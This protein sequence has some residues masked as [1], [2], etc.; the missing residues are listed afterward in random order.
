[1][2]PDFPWGEQRDTYL[3]EGLEWAR[4][5]GTIDVA[6]QALRA[7]DPAATDEEIARLASRN[8]LSASP[9]AIEMLTRAPS[10]T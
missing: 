1:M 2:G 10:D 7:Q 3:R 5:W 8:R 9:G 4:N 6:A